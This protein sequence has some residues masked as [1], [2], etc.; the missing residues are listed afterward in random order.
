[1]AE[2]PK[3]KPYPSDPTDTEWQRIEPYVPKPKP[4]GRPRLHPIREI[5]DAIFY[6]LRAGCA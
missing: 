2:Q 5:L 4:G 3:R 1:M 6:I